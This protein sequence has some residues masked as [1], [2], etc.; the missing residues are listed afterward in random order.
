MW[1]TCV[2]RLCGQTGKSSGWC[3]DIPYYQRRTVLQ[4]GQPLTEWTLR[5]LCP[6]FSWEGKG[7]VFS[8]YSLPPGTLFYTLP[9]TEEQYGEPQPVSVVSLWHGSVVWASAC[10]R[11]STKTGSA[12]LVEDVLSQDR[13]S[14]TGGRWSSLSTRSFVPIPWQPDAPP[15]LKIWSFR[16]FLLFLS[17]IC[18]MYLYQEWNNTFD[19][20]ISSFNQFLR[21]VCI[22]GEGMFSEFLRRELSSQ[23]RGILGWISEIRV[24]W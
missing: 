9:L 15:F 12:L 22:L 2:S 19:A 8:S 18:Q 10:R 7:R 5:E 21:D 4:E 16:R 1:S 6:Y 3:S 11:N 23:Y 17:G 20:F 13:S 14:Q 24:I